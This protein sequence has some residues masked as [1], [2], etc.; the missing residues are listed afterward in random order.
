MIS[1]R[2]L[3]RLRPLI[4]PLEPL[5]AH[6]TS[7][8]RVLDIGC[9]TGALLLRAVVEGRVREGLGTDVSSPALET[10]CETWQAMA[11]QFPA[12]QLRFE[13]MDSLER[14]PGKW[15][16]VMMIDVIHHVPPSMQET[17]LRAAFRLVAPE[18]RMIY[19]DVCLR[20]FWKRA[21][22]RLHD[23]VMARQWISEVPLDQVRQWAAEEGLKV[24]AEEHYSRL[25]YGHELLVLGREAEGSV[26]IVDS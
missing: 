24:I 4:C 12:S 21:M 17:F 6:M 13:R 5:L 3:Q 2:L 25:W 19:K 9:G 11:G 8:A 22:N 16:V 18:G 15:E 23:L 20:P 26:S 14:L 1:R 10:A 7:A